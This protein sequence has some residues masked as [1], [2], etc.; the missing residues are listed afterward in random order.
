[1]FV[2]FL[3]DC[4]AA[5]IEL[6]DLLAEIKADPS[7]LTNL[8]FLHARRA[9]ATSNLTNLVIG[10]MISGIVIMRVFI[11][12]ISDAASNLS[13]TEATI[14]NL[15]PLFAVLLLLIALAS[16]LMRRGG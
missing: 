7:R 1:M 12:V 11:P 15:L 6:A 5:L 16:P 3:G 8:T 13:G 2:G 14:A 10:I 9:Q 4:K